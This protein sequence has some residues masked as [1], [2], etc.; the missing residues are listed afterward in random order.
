MNDFHT[1]KTIQCTALAYNG[2]GGRYHSL[3]PYHSCTSGHY[4]HWPEYWFCT[5]DI[6]ISKI[7]KFKL[8]GY[9]NIF[10]PGIAL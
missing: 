7:D 2:E 1:G 9:P 6:R 8:C 3:A 4:E 10:L 5:W